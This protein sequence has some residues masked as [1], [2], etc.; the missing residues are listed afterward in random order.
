MFFLG[1]LNRALPLGHSASLLPV[2]VLV[3]RTSYL[4]QTSATPVACRSTPA[5]ASPGPRSA[6][7]KW[8]HIKKAHDP[9]RGRGLWKLRNDSV[10]PISLTPSWVA[11][12]A[13]RTETTGTRYA[14]V[15]LV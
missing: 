14:S 15:P 13:H 3:V 5:C 4:A 12:T 7:E 1:S 6:A 8:K 10:Q 11:S 2:V 9:A